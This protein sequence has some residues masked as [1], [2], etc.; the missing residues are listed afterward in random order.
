MPQ[1]N[2]LIDNGGLPL[3]VSEMRRKLAQVLSRMNGDQTVTFYF[4]A[5]LPNYM[6]AR[7]VYPGAVLDM[8]THSDFGIEYGELARP[9]NH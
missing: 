4:H 6:P 1:L 5:N 2:I 9:E 3:T 7:R 8:E